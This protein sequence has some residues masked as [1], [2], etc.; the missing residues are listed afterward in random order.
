MRTSYACKITL[1]ARERAAI[2]RR[3]DLHSEYIKGDYTLMFGVL[4][5]V[6]DA[7]KKE[8]HGKGTNRGP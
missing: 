7:S 1:T 4:L 6:L 8:A 2:A 5:R 3:L